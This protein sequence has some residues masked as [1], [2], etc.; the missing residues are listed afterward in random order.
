MQSGLIPIKPARAAVLG[1][2]I[3]RGSQKN[4]NRGMSKMSADVVVNVAHAV[5]K[6]YFSFDKVIIIQLILEMILNFN[7]AK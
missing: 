4:H 3:G 2:L 7:L 6:V 1:F 5:L